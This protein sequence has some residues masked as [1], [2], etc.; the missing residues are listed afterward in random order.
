VPQRS[1]ERISRV[2]LDQDTLPAL[3]KLKGQ[4]I[5]ELA[6][7]QYDAFQSVHRLAG[8]FSELTMLDITKFGTPDRSDAHSSYTLDDYIDVVSRFHF[9]ERL[10]DLALWEGIEQ[11]PDEQERNAVVTKLLQNCP[12]LTHLG[13]WGTNSKAVVDIVLV[14]GAEVSWEQ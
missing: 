5:R 1:L 7:G 13:H 6:V 10:P 14:R 4:G 9:L 3:G 2:F 8:L 11:L 12:N